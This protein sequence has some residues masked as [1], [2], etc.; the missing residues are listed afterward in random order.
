M[1]KILLPTPDAPPRRGGV[2]R[3][4]GAILRARADVEI[5]TLFEDWG[6]MRVLW[7]LRKKTTDE[8][9]QM[10]THHIFPVG[11]ACYLLSNIIRRPFAYTVFLHGLDFDL[12]RRNVWK[13]FLARRILQSAW[14]IIVNSVSLQKEVSAFIGRDDVQVVHPC[15]SAEFVKASETTRRGIVHRTPDELAKIFMSQMVAM[16][17][18]G[19]SVSKNTSHDPIRLITVARLVER[20]GH[21]KVLRAM[22]D[23]AN[24]TYT[25]VGDGLVRESL[26]KEAEELGVASRVLWLTE[27]TDEQ[28]PSLYATHDIFVMPTTKSACDREGFGIVYAE[29]GIFGLPCIATNIPG[30]DEVVLHEVTGI[31]IEDTP[32]ALSEAIKKLSSSPGLRSRMGTAARTYVLENFTEER[33]GEMIRQVT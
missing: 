20:K 6:T 1:F 33:F 9:R 3:Y 7:E 29:A 30:V 22:V 19:I 11:T 28:L 5:Y 21:A 18:S 27:V 10:W 13:R 2:A 24:T 4:I 15:V 25:I 8:I 17:G 26:K 12:A 23:L 32:H 31:L 14:G 16:T